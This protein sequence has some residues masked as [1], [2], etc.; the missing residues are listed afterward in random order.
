LLVAVLAMFVL[1]A[2][3]S[4]YLGGVTFLEWLHKELYQGYTYQLMFLFHLVV[5]LVLVVP[6]LVFI[7]VHTRNVWQR[8][9]R[10]AVYAGLGLF[11]AVLVLLISGLLLVRF[12][13][14]FIRS[15][16]LRDTAYWLHLLAPLACVWLF[17]LH[18]LAGP[19]LR[20]RGG[21]G[22]L[23]VGGIFALGMVVL[24]TLDP[25]DWS[26][27]ATTAQA[28]FSPALTQTA[29]GQ[30]IPAEVMMNDQYCAQCHQD[31]HEQWSQS[32]HRFSSFNNP[33]YRMAVN[34]TR[35]MAMARDG[36]VSAARFC[37]GCHDLVPLLSGAFDD[38]AFDQLNH[39]E[40]QAGLTCTSCH[41]IT[42]VNSPRGNADFTVEEP[43][44]YPFAFSD[45]ATL[46]WI[47]A[48]LIKAN[49]GFHKQ[50]F[51][52]P[53]HETAEFCSTCHK[54]NLP[55]EFNG[56]KWLR[57]QNHYDSFLLSG[58][59]GH[60]VSSFYYPPEAQPNCNQCH[61][62]MVASNDVGATSTLENGESAVRNHM[63]PSA[64]TAIP[65]LVGMPP[66]VIEAHKA[67]S[68]GALRIDLVALREEGRIDGPLLG[69]LRPQVPALKPGA[70]YLLQTIVRTLKLGHHFTQGTADSNQV[71][72]EV[73][74]AHEGEVF[75]RSG[76]LNPDDR[77]VDPW[78][79]FVNSY[80][81]DREGNRIERRN[82]EDIFVPLYNHQIGP[83][84]ADLLHY[85]L[86]VPDAME[87]ELSV[88]ARLYYRKFD[89]IIMQYTLQVDDYVNDLPITLMASDT[90]VFP[91]G[92]N[93][94]PRQVEARDI[95][96]WQRWNDYG[97]GALLK[98]QRR[99]LR[100]A[101]DVFQRVEALGKG[102]GALNL[103]RV[104]LSEG[105]LQEASAAIQRASQ[106]DDPPPPWSIAWF[107]GV[108]LF[109]EGRF[110]AALQA[111]DALYET[112]FP[113]AR[114]RG[115]DF[116]RD[117][118]LI[119]QIGLTWLE[120]S[121]GQNGE[122][123][124]Q[125]QQEAQRWFELALQQD[126]ENSIAHY[127]LTQL[128]RT[129]GNE[130]QASVH[131]QLH[132]RYRVDDNARDRAIAAARRRD[133]AAD[134]AA[135]PVVIYDLQRPGAEAFSLSPKHAMQ[136]VASDER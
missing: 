50:T 81:L 47:N 105:R 90:V 119:N 60:G 121:R 135:D 34:N 130:E 17:V 120:I 21:M 82:P 24:Q 22:V 104:Y 102:T 71:W 80:V 41:A 89:N 101:E 27:G 122:Q 13:A 8:P 39:P 75:A 73:E 103:A 113:E 62:P 83:G 55:E 18:R 11:V 45:N 19:K 37:A 36:D 43:V 59:S 93:A 68:E 107:S 28:D 63:F 77:S 35:E 114:A 3:N 7:A 32:V 6:A 16:W 106:S 5:G 128:H 85:R 96:E 70:S 53:H 100:Q 127:N 56:Y 86:D 111:F 42:A 15:G 2:V 117:Y 91:V 94:Q 134:H 52:K 126:P 97:I 51:L 23:A 129:M 25:R 26:P 66:S 131:A 92:E 69:P 79:H 109:Q 99:Q 98:P 125:S 65:H 33:V 1:L 40:G 20:W 124:Q 38:P 112:Q 30:H 88:T 116:S 44:H 64:N 57:G 108:L 118:R 46:A 61:M 58:V 48:Q 29:S 136:G 31:V 76:G 9:N 72:V 4:A 95:P 115:F 84:T 67:F 14:F 78:S 49:P 74:V 123:Q 133:P 54:V 87:G 110:E 132:Q 12:D 10:R